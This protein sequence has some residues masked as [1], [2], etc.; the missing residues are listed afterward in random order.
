MQFKIQHVFYC[1]FIINS[2]SFIIIIY[3]IDFIFIISS[4]SFIIITNIIMV[5]WQIRKPVDDPWQVPGDEA[6]TAELLVEVDVLHPLPD[7]HHITQQEGLHQGDA[8]GVH[9]HC[10]EFATVEDFFLDII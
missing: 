2:I 8:H 9:I 10:C 4:I 5:M 3:N 7:H 1:F 6:K